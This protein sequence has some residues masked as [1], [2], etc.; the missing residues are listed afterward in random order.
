M[1]LPLKAI[2]DLFPPELQTSLRKQP[3]EHVQVLIPRALIEP[4]LAGGAVR[5]TFAQIRAATPEIFFYTDRA[6]ADAKLLLPL[7]HVLREM[8]PCRR[9]DQRQPSVPISIPSIFSKASPSRPGAAPAN[10]SKE[11]WYSQRLPTYEA[12][13]EPEAEATP[14]ANG[15]K[16]YWPLASERQRRGT[17][18][19]AAPSTPPEPSVPSS[20]LSPVSP[21]V[22]EGLKGPKGPTGPIPAAADSGPSGSFAI[23]VEAVLSAL[24]PEIRNALTDSDGRS[25]FFLIPLGEF[26]ARMRTGK[27]LFKWGQ[28]QDWS[29]VE[30][31]APVAPDLDVDLPLAEVV[32]LFMAARKTPDTRKQFEVDTRIPD[33]FSKSAPLPAAPA[34]QVHAEPAP[35]LP[36]PAALRPA[37]AATGSAQL[38]GSLRSLDGVAGAFI[39]TA[40]G[41]LVAGEV[42]DANEEVLAAF[43]PTVF[44]Q[45]A[46][47]SDMAR[48]GLPEAIDIHLASS[49]VHVHKAGKL[50]LG[51]LMPRGH[52]LPAQELTRISNALQPHTS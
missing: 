5:I 45:L 10:G 30:L 48:L 26:E 35:P 41:L 36:Q 4:Q 23:P 8:M 37:P 9:D 6:P 11:A 7:Y 49:T 25:A 17:E 13:P 47:Y 31:S 19:V 1:A 33:L 43:A 24:P 29:N 21:T 50:F 12:P 38:L 2:T 32:P 16:P 44:A 40:D 39:A 34:P 28:L 20:P 22:P 15:K 51:L 14:P 52:P 3:S 42:P 46:K 27:L 18:P